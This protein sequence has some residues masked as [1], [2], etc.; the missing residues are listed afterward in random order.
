[1]KLAFAEISQEKSFYS[2]SEADWF[3][4][5]EATCSQPV[6]AEIE[7][8]K[9][10]QK[11]VSLKGMLQF[12][13][14]LACDRCGVP[15]ERPLKE[16]FEYILTL[17]EQNDV[18]M[19]ELECSDEDCNT[20]YLKEP[21]IDVGA[22]LREQAFLAVPVRTLCAED[23]KGL[24]PVCGAL[25]KNENCSCSSGNSNSPFAVLERLRKA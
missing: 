15:V 18:E 23:C 20:L 14:L 10:T 22:I 2:L 5:D 3:P 12:S 21:V 16:E 7:V 4:V 19:P 11:T 1:M 24:C 8:W 13:A 6:L 9:K 17:E 25:L